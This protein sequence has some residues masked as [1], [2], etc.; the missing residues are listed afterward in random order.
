MAYQETLATAPSYAVLA[1]IGMF[2][3]VYLAGITSVSGGI[4]AGVL[5]AGGIVFT[6]SAKY[7]HGGDYYPV[8]SGILLVL[9]VVGYPEGITGRLHRLLS[10][11]RPGERRATGPAWTSE[12]KVPARR[13][14]GDPLFSTIGLRVRYGGIVAVND[15]TLQVRRGE[16]VGLIGP[17]GAG[18]T[19]LIDAITGFA[20][21]E[22]TVRLGDIPV[23]SLRPHH[24][25]RLGLGR[26]FQGLELYDDL[27]V[28]ENVE[29]GSSAAS[30]FPAARRSETAVLT[31]VLGLLELAPVADRAVA[32]L[33]QGQRQLVSVARALAGAPAIALLDEPAAGLDTSE[34]RWLGERL[35]SVRDAGVAILLVDH[36]MELVL[37]VCDRII[38]LDLGTVI[39]EG[40]P[41]EIRDDPAVVRAYLGTP[42]AV[43]GGM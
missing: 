2:A 14:N 1:G 18:K 28:R 24:R 20:D 11:I 3:V 16:I 10:R 33:S 35:R 41:Q 30:R 23:Q 39:A 27:T 31:S 19:T 26:S 34:S 22:G 12:P 6:L 5:G 7:L 36:D 13:V 21:A 37:D 15:V 40:T 38:V 8:I 32:T 42:H 43:T 25:S 4:L 9:I 29:V 17:N